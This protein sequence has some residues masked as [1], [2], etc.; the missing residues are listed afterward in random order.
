[1]FWPCRYPPFECGFGIETRCVHVAF[2]VTREGRGTG[3][4]AAPSNEVALPMLAKNLGVQGRG[5]R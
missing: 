5:T 3:S 1:M 2:S 4:A